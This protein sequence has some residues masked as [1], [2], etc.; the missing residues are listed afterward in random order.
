MVIKQVWWRGALSLVNTAVVCAPTS[1]SVLEMLFLPIPTIPTL[2]CC[3]LVAV[4]TCSS[5]KRLI[6]GPSPP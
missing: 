4:R 5:I 3:L 6:K 1:T 2:F